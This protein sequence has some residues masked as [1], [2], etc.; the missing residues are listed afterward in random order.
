MQKHLSVCTGKVGYE[1]SFD[2]GEIIDYQEHYRILEMS[3]FLFTMILKPL[4]V[5]QFF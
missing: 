4:P 3:R 2:N 5:A 1:F